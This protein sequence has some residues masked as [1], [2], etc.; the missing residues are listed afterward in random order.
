MIKFTLKCDR[1]HRF[2]SWFASADAFD[3][4]NK[5]GM[6]TCA[7]CGSSHVEKAL[8]APNVRDSKTAHSATAEG[9][10]R[11]MAT[12]EGAQNKATSRNAIGTYEMSP[13]HENKLRDIQNRCAGK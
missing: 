6:V 3:K 10:Q 2:D 9:A 12:K 4:L 11:P 5:S 1:D 7:V 13:K 8:M